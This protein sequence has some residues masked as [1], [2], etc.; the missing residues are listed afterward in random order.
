[1]VL[2]R[3]GPLLEV[4]GIAGIKSDDRT[5]AQQ[6]ALVDYALSGRETARELKK[7]LHELTSKPPRLQHGTAMGLVQR[8]SPRRTF[9]HLRGDFLAPGEEVHAGT[10]AFL[11]ELKRRGGEPDR[12]DLAR[13]ILDPDNPLTARVTVNRFWQQYFG[14]G[15][16]ESGEDFGSEGSPPSHPQ[17]LDWLAS[18]FVERDWSMKRL[19]RLIVC[20]A[21]YRQSGAARPE[22]A[23]RDPYNRWL[24]RQNRRRVEAET[25]RDLALAAGGLLDRRVKGP[26]VFPPLPAGIIE[27]AFVDVI[28]RN[29]WRV[30]TGGDRYRR[31]L[32]TY[33]QR[34]SPYPM[35]TLF[36]APDS[37]TA[38]TRRE[39]SNTPLQALTLWND[40]VFMECCRALAGRV[41]R[42]VPPGPD[43]ARQ[44]I[45]HAVALCLS[46][47]P[48][49]EER[50]DLMRLYRRSLAQFEADPRGVA[51]LLGGVTLPDSTSPP[52]LAAWTAVAR[53]LINLD[54]FITKE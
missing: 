17:L 32:Y 29:P 1:M 44:R 7:K 9:T 38:C 45:D 28:D 33:F 35:L 6:D 5:P 15:I 12:L 54:E 10:P 52:E 48:E 16:V 37:N 19:H 23:E 27:L 42:E 53:A 46:R 51:D 25:V 8:E 3:D 40:P 4:I 43:A 11:H 30:S 2:G 18:R 22:L 13:W 49:Q 26:S 34:T 47:E 14:R 31:G 21:T 41:A 39:S 24:A 20:S 50:A 36:D